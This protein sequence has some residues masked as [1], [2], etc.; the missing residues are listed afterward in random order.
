MMVGTLRPAFPEASAPDRASP[1]PPA[2]PGRALALLVALS[3]ALN[4][5][6]IGWGL[7]NGTFDWSN[8]SVAPLE[9]L[10]WAKRTLHGEPWTSKYPPFH[11]MV[12][13]AG[14]APYLGVLK[15]TGGFARPTDA[16][17]YGFADPERALMV[18]TLIA[19]LVSVTMG[20][21]LVVLTALTARRLAGPRAG[22]IAGL[23][24]ATSLPVVHYAHN[25]N[26][27]V[28][29]LFWTALAL[30]ALVGY[31]QTTARRH[32]VTLGLAA[33]AAVGTKNSVYALFVGV[34]LVLVGAHLHHLRRTVGL[35]GWRRAPGTRHL[36]AGL[37]AFLLGLVVAF[38]VPFNWH[39]VARHVERHLRQSV[40]GNQLLRQEPS[41]VRGE[42]ALIGSYLRFLGAANA[43]PVAAL[44]AAGLGWALV[45][46]RPLAVLVLVPAVTY[47][48]L[49]L[50]LHGTHHLRYVL[51]VYLLL[52]WPAAALAARALGDGPARRRLALAALGAALGWGGLEAASVGLR[53]A[54][55]P[56]YEAEAWLRA[57]VPAG[58]TVLGVA[59][60]YTLPRFPPGVRVER[61]EIWDYGGRQVGDLVDLAPAYVAIGTNLPAR[62][63]RRERIEEFFQARGYR[64]QVE[65]AP[66]VSFFAR[67]VEDLHSLSPRVAIYARAGAAATAPA[68]GDQAYGT[69]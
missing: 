42:L 1:R 14:Y 40:G 30:W 43:A 6:G 2:R 15:L 21:G 53:Y 12:L 35:R 64:R 41:P 58:A 48:L 7:P 51:P 26:V 50:R 25:A 28:P 62:R 31:L 23:L 69:R 27:D 3:L 66:R 49:F 24:V 32:A 9:P 68:P 20:V 56:R 8:D 39:G 45:R 65:F 55:D 54:H 67:E 4:L 11:F 44:L 37:A 34:A 18:L 17:P 33:A 10:A 52:T 19:R 29:H 60:N 38:N 16:Y 59:P 57:H 63:A 47:Y 61:R 22:T 5:Y 36:A 46:A 13:A